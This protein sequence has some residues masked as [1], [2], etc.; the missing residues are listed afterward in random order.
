MTIEVLHPVLPSAAPCDTA[1]SR[2]VGEI[3]LHDSFADLVEL[4]NGDGYHRA[5]LLVRDGTDVRGFIDVGVDT[6]TVLGREIARE[7]ARLPAQTPHAGTSVDAPPVS[8]VLC[9]RDR[10]EET[11][12]VITSL[13]A[14]DYPDFEIVVVDNAASSLDTWRHVDSLDNPRVRAVHASVPGLAAARNRGLE[15]ARHEIVA[16]TDDDVL[17][18]RYW[19]TCLTRPFTDPAVGCVTGLVPAA[20][21]RTAPQMVFERRVGWSTSVQRRVFRLSDSSSHDGL[22]PFRVA[23]YGTGAN[24]A[25][26]R[27]AAFALGGFD[28]A[29]GAGSPTRGGEDIDWFVRTLAAGH[30]LVFEPD[31]ITWHQHR[32]DDDALL[33]QAHGYGLGLGAWMTK[34][35]TDRHLAPLALARFP[36]AVRHLATS[37]RARGTDPT[38]STT[39]AGA[40]RAEVTGLLAGPRALLTARAQGRRSAP[41]N[42]FPVLAPAALVYTAHRTEE[43]PPSPH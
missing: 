38:T 11:K 41:F 18:D 19:L 1:D 28:E 35:V 21:L 12:R 15:A 24:F 26:R 23:D 9:T 37:M 42:R 17:A 39:A 27:S 13:L 43:E 34:V 8:V 30:T 4:T 40:T 32:D 31:A 3:Q 33:T 36:V 5:R 25:V 29:L 16:F 10:T 22:F 7:A 6:A 20:E 14:V 2:W